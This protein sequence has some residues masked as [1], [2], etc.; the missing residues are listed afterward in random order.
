MAAVYIGQEFVIRTPQAAAIR[1]AAL[2]R[3]GSA[4]H[5]TD[6][7]QRYI[8]LPITARQDDRIQVATPA[9]GSVSPPGY[10]MVWIVDEQGAPCREAFWLLLLPAIANYTAGTFEYHGKSYNIHVHNAV[11]SRRSKASIFTA[12]CHDEDTRAWRM[13]PRPAEDRS[14]R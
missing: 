7:Q 4:T 11:P 6:T 1:R 8:D 3:P 13:R 2:L 10:Y 12:C 9:D 14:R 5:H